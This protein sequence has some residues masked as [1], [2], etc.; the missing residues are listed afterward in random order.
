MKVSGRTAKI[1]YAK[2]KKRNQTLKRS[3][4]L[5]VSKARGAVTYVK[6]SGQK[7]IVI[8]KKTGRVTVKK[9]LKKGTYRIKVKVQAAGNSSYLPS[10]V[11]TVTFK[12]KII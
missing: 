11:K 9:G 5:T 10:S 3:A 1:K 12:I 6:K 2:V 7:K 8:A 4:V